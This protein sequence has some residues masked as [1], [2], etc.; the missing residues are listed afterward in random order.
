MPERL[1]AHVSVQ[2]GVERAPV[3]GKAIGATAI[4]VFTKTPSQW[5][6][7][8]I[9]VESHAAFRRECERCKLATIVAHDSYLI[10]LASPDR[11]LSTRSQTSFIAELRRCEAFGIPYLVSHPGNYIDN[12]AAGLV[13]NAAAYSRSLRAVPGAVVVLLETTAGCGTALGSTFEELATLRALIADDVR[14]RVAFCA[15][16]CHLYSA[17]YDLVGDYDGVWERWDRVVGLKLLHCLHLNDSKTKFASR[18]DRH[19]LIAEGTLGPQPFRRIMTDA[20]LAHI[21]KILETPKGEDGVT[22]DRKMLRRLRRY[23]SP[24]R[25]TR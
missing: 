24:R 15:D 22:A 10:N 20:R 6:E 14:H 1:G 9:S 11:Q 23:A 18:C 19:E 16:T 3:R 2:G 5:R 8:G 4:Q 12:R 21:I 7:P 13:R 17:G 25:P